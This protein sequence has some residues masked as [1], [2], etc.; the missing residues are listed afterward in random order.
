MDEIDRLVLQDEVHGNGRMLV[1]E[2]HDDAVQM[3]F[4]DTGRAVQAQT[5][6]DGAGVTPDRLDRG[7]DG[8]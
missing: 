4:A 7:I 5:S 2:I 1:L 3:A 8:R 6:V